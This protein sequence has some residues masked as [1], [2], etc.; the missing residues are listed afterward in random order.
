LAKRELDDKIV[1]FNQMLKNSDDPNDNLQALVDHLTEFTGASAC[2][3]GKVDKPIK[4]VKNGLL[5]DDN[6]QAH[7]IPGS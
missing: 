2:Y 7:H 3:V 5:E 6:D 1:K 4:G